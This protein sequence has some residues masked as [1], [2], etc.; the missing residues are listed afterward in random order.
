MVK[1]ENLRFRNLKHKE[2]IKKDGSAYEIILSAE[3][4]EAFIK[5]NSQGEEI[6]VVVYC[7]SPG[8]Y[9]YSLGGKNEDI[10]DIEL[11][12]DEEMLLNLY[13]LKTN[14]VLEESERLGIELYEDD[15]YHWGLF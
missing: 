5:E 7:D 9:S 3:F 12:E 8:D 13:I 14:L 11:N 15:K 1:E 4:E 10:D 2:T 6:W